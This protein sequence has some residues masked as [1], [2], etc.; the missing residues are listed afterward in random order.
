LRKVREA[1]AELELTS[2]G[3]VAKSSDELA[4]ED[5]AE[6]TDG[7][8]ERAPGRDPVRAVWSETAGCNDAVDVRMKLQS[9]IPAVKHAEEADLGTEVP[10]IRPKKSAGLT[11]TKRYS[12]P[13]TE[14]GGVRI[15]ELT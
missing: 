10:W 5:T 7:Q 9:L 4:A 3:C 8:E 1:A 6:H 11:V 12:C 2:M 14:R 13:C 15:V